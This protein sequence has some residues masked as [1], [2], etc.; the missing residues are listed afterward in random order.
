MKKIQYTDFKFSCNI[1]NQNKKKYLQASIALI[2]SHF[3][4]YIVKTE[5]QFIRIADSAEKYL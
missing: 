3:T 5:E 2:N 1:Q 4:L